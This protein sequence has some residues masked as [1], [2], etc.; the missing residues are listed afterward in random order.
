[1]RVAVTGATGFI[2]KR[3][4]NKLLARGFQINCLV[5]RTEAQKDP[6]IKLV[7]GSLL[8]TDALK[9]LMEDVKGLFHL[10]AVFEIGTSRTDMYRV[11]VEGTRQVLAMASE[12]RL[13]RIVYCSTVAALGNTRDHIAD[14]NWPHDGTFQSEYCRTKYLAHIAA[15]EFIN[16]G[17]PIVICMPSVVYGKDDPSTLGQSWRLYIQGKLPL[18]LAPDTRLTYVHVDDAAEGLILAFERG[19]IGQSYILAGE[20]K[21]NLEVF[22]LIDRVTG[23]T[24]SKRRLPFSVAKVLAVVDELI[25]RIQKRQ[26]LLSSEGIRMLENCHW[27]VTAAKAQRELGWTARSL[28]AGLRELLL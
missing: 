17:L 13:E 6:R 16:R 14:E 2:G 7:K 18:I 22:E 21:T 3:L 4:V 26:P 10:A 20:V 28:D 19:Q 11:N 23:R 24:R 5:H 8:D 12:M 15:K 27:A 9:R 25:S 1:M